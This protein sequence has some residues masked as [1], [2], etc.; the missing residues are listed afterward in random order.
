MFSLPLPF[1]PFALSFS[2]PIRNDLSLSLASLLFCRRVK[3]IASARPNTV[4]SHSIQ[5]ADRLESLAAVCRASVFNLNQERNS[6]EALPLS[7]P[8]LSSIMPLSPKPSAP[9]PVPVHPPA[10]SDPSP[11]FT[12]TSTPTPFMSAPA[13]SVAAS[14]STSAPLTDRAASP[15]AKRPAADEATTSQIK[16]V[17][18]IPTHRFPSSCLLVRDG[19]SLARSSLPSF[20]SGA[21][22]DTTLV[23]FKYPS[24]SGGRVALRMGTD[25]IRQHVSGHHSFEGREA[26]RTVSC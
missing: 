2:R 8:P 23:A 5:R 22:V 1:C 11:I 15:G 3:P 9:A 18:S 4:F 26:C 14:T 19:P 6:L 24:L 25:L 7:L 13:P 12:S 17:S 10:R 21:A 20:R 16:Y